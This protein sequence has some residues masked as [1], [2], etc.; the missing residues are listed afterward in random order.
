MLCIGLDTDPSQIPSFLHDEDDPVFSFNKMIIEATSAYA[1]AYK[2]NTAF[3]EAQGPRGWNSLIKTLEVIPPNIFTIADA[4]R[5][6]IGNSSAQYARTFF[7][8]YPFDSVT[9]SPYMGADSVTPFL[10]YKGKWTII[11]GLT[12]NTG[13]ADFQMLP[14]PDKPLYK[15]VL[16]AAASWGTSSNTMFVIGATQGSLLAEI[17]TLLPEHFFLVP[18]VG[19]QGGDVA[20]VCKAAMNKDVGLLIN[21][22]RAVIYAGKGPDFAVAARH[23]AEY[24]QSEMKAYF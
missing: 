24:Y 7:E 19:S 9:V 11:L 13:S 14:C 4:K 3:Y 20:E 21:V 6:D 17:R 12:S 1:V 18:G 8:T 10:A 15:K 16:T 22:S 23:A 2:L 5:G